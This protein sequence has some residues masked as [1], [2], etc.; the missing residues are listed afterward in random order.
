MRIVTISD[1]H[2]FQDQLDYVPCDLLLIAGDVGTV[3]DRI[4][5]A[6]VVRQFL[7]WVKYYPATYKVLVAGNHDTSIESRF[8]TLQEIADHDVIYLEH[9]YKDVAGYKIFG[10]PY[11]PSFGEGWAFNKKRHHLYEY[12]SEIPEN[13]DILITHGPPLGILDLS[14]AGRSG[15][16]N[17]GDRALLNKVMEIKPKVHVFGHIHDERDVFNHGVFVRDET[18]F[19]NA[20]IVNLH[21]NKINKPIIWD[22]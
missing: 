11:T 16:D 2:G 5:N 14:A 18:A 9:E 20:S 4:Q 13:T 7:H 3:R 21:Y 12:W 8:I 1:T 10:S 19:I 22:I 15:I 6:V 17:C